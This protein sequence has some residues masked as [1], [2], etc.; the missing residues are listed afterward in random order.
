MGGMPVR[1]RLVAAGYVRT[2]RYRELSPIGAVVRS[3]CARRANAAGSGLRHCT[4]DAPA[5]S[6]ASS[7]SVNPSMPLQSSVDSTRSAGPRPSAAARSR[8][9]SS[10]R[11]T[12]A[13]A[14]AAASAGTGDHGTNSSPCWRTSVAKSITPAGS[15][16]RPLPN[17][18]SDSATT[19]PPGSAASARSIRSPSLNTQSASIGSVTSSAPHHQAASST[20]A[21]CQCAGSNAATRVPGSTSHSSRSRL[22]ALAAQ[23]AVVSP[24]S[25]MRSPVASS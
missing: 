17:A 24:D 21:V 11:V 20:A 8:A 1:A 18:S 19:P 14:S 12:E 25:S 16:G 6:T 13:P 4:S 22:A 7:P 2:R 9:P 15:P 10:T 23:F 5:A 3:A